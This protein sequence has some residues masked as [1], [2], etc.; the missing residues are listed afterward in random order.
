M[1][2]GENIRVL[3]V[4]DEVDFLAATSKALTRRGFKVHIAAN[5][6]EAHTIFQEHPVDVIILDVKMTDADGH[7]LFY[8]FKSRRPD[9]QIIILSGHGNVQRA[10]EMARD[11]LF[12]YITK[13]CDIDHLASQ[14]RS[15]DREA[16]GKSAPPGEKEEKVRVLLVD[17]E[18]DF[19]DATARVLARRGLSV[20]KA[21]SGREAL[22]I[23]RAE[24]VDVAV[25]DVKMPSMGGLELVGHIK[26]VKPEIKIILLTGHA[27]V[28]S[29]VQGMRGKVFDYL[30]KPHDPDKLAEKIHLAARQK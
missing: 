3:L 16:K 28:E 26:E 15:A 10:F 6:D 19:V 8:E 5:S 2:S 11:G 13:P 30:F 12:D 21:Y 18:K 27:T 7:E 1:A 14:I 9:V 23:I 20:L 22:D 24:K 4:D 25:V 17:D 29:G